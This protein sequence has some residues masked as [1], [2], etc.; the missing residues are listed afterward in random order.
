MYLVPV[1]ICRRQL[2]EE[3]TPGVSGIFSELNTHP[4]RHFPSLLESLY[5]GLS[6][7]A[8]ASYEVRQSWLDSQ[9]G[10]RPFW[11]LVLNRKQ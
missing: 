5:L 1:S 10:H 2:A 9:L 11:S 3:P 8:A 6:L 4:H 7:Q